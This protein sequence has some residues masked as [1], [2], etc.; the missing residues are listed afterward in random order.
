MEHPPPTVQLPLA[1]RW[2]DAAS[3][4]SF[5]AAGNRQALAAVERLLTGSEGCVYLHGASG[6]GKSHLLQ[7]ASRCFGADGAPVA[8]VPLGQNLCLS[9]EVLHGLETLQ[10]VALDDLGAVACKPAWEEGVFHAFNRMRDTGTRVLLSASARPEA[11]G[12]QLPDLVSRLQ[13]GLMERLSPMDDEQKLGALRHRARLRGLDLPLDVGRYLLRRQ[14]RD[15]TSLFRLLEV[16][17]RAALAEQ[18]RLTIPF[19]RRVL[20]HG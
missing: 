6:T 5:H 17:D 2:N 20:G 13:W 16:L 4:D 14:P 15:T 1:I 7:A 8:Y 18:R 3:F 12:F 9:P 11:I 19:L 10:L